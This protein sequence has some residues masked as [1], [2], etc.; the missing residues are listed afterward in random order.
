MLDRINDNAQVITAILADNSINYKNDIDLNFVKGLVQIL[1]PIEEF[2]KLLSLRNASISLVLPIYRVLK[3]QLSAYKNDDVLLMTF[4]NT[5]K[6]QL[7]T[8]MAKYKHK[9]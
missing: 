5:V 9:R 8:R 1:R 7:V 3:N 4:V 6:T 2:T